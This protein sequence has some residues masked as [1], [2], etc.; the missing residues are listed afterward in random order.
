MIIG[1]ENEDT[2][3]RGSGF[4]QFTLLSEIV[5]ICLIIR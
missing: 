3:I 2:N 4:Q 1:L 5:M